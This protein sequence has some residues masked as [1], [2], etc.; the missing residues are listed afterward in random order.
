MCLIVLVALGFPRIGLIL[1]WLFDRPFL[2]NAY[3][4]GFL[5]LLGFIFLPFTTLGYAWARTFPG[6]AFSTLGVIVLVLALLADLGTFR[7]GVA[8]RGPSRS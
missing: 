6:G 3:S 2:E 7:M 4:S 8:S 5:I 1:F